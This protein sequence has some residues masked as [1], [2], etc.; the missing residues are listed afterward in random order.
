MYDSRVESIEFIVDE[1]SAVTGVPLKD[2]TLKPNLLIACISRQG[3][4]FI[5]G[6]NDAIAPGDTVII[7]TTH[8][9]FN[10]LTDILA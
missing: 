10:D 6:G 2:L 3:H 7:V 4:V 1:E 9:G 8:T 5:P